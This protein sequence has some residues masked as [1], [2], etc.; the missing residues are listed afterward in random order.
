MRVALGR[1]ARTVAATAAAAAC[2]V[3][4]LRALLRLCGGW[5]HRRCRGLTMKPLTFPCRSA[6]TAGGR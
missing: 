3:R 1:W 4:R 5:R 6:G 2:R